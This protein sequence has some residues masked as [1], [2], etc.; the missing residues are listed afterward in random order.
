M[1]KLLLAGILLLVI[2]VLYILGWLSWG[3]WEFVS[4][5]FDNKKL[6]ASRNKLLFFLTIGKKGSLE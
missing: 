1:K 5:F 6:K 4:L 3:V 2:V